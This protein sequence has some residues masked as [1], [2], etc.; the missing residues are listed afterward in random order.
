MKVLFILTN[1]LILRKFKLIL[2]TVRLIR[3]RLLKTGV[4]LSV[5]VNCLT[6]RI[7]ALGRRSFAL[8]SRGGRV[9]IEGA[10]LHLIE[11][12]IAKHKKI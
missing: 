6:P 3:S 10:F 7:S 2:R 8:L 9:Q 1:I 11:K 4:W 12:I 5:R